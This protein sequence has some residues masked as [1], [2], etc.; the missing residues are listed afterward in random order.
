MILHYF[1]R[2]KVNSWQLNT[3][4]D[5]T[6]TIQESRPINMIEKN[7]SLNASLS[8]VFLWWIT[9]F[10]RLQNLNSFQ[11]NSCNRHT[12]ARIRSSLSFFP[13]RKILTFFEFRP[14][15]S[16]SKSLLLSKDQ[17]DNYVIE[18]ATTTLSP[19]TSIDFSILQ[20]QILNL[21]ESRYGLPSS[22]ITSSLHPSKKKLRQY[23]Y[24]SKE[25][26]N[27]MD[28][29]NIIDVMDYLDKGK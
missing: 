2:W 12:R 23:L 5:K 7:P 11:H 21:V 13:D 10:I 19:S 14:N 4:R 9:L 17:S 29:E 27:P 6:G 8:V 18:N 16:W 25:R 20:E 24:H 26:K 15:Q 3:F 1:D 28:I 22:P